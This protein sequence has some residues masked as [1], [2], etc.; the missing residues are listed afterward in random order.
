MHPSGW[1]GNQRREHMRRWFSIVFGKQDEWSPATSW[2]QSGGICVWRGGGWG[3][4]CP[5]G[6]D[7]LGVGSTC[8]GRLPGG[9]HTGAFEF[10][11]MW[12]VGGCIAKHASCSWLG[13]Q[14]SAKAD[15]YAFSAGDTHF[16]LLN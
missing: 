3:G 5:G 8:A 14:T 2:V 6:G 16:N 15:A 1:G 9:E 11:R 12:W 10:P 7:F 13:S 4:V